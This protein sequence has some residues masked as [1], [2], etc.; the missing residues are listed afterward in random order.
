ME[1]KETIQSWCQNNFSVQETARV[2]HIH[3]NTLYYRIHKIENL[4]DC[5]MRNFTRM[6]ELYLA[7]QLEKI[8]LS[9]HTP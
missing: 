1:L 8:G 7:I 6:M 5:S 9:A 4:Y 3:R 2:L